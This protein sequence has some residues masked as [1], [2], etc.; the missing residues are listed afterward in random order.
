MALR[1]DNIRKRVELKQACD[2]GEKLIGGLKELKPGEF[3]EMRGQEGNHTAEGEELI[4]RRGKC[5]KLSW[6]EWRAA[7]WR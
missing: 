7:G 5:M 3:E 1:G 2:K 4:G 6:R